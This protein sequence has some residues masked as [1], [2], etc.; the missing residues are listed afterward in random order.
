MPRVTFA[1]PPNVYYKLGYSQ[2]VVVAEAR[3]TLYVSGQVALDRE[4]KLIGSGDLEVQAEK[5][6]ENLSEIL[7]WAGASL[8]DLVKISVYTTKLD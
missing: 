3:K 8:D 5:V 7:K 1:N 4:G 6:F 2:A